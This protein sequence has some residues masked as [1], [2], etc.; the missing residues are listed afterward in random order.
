V[1]LQNLTD[2]EFNS[3]VRDSELPVIVDFWAAW[4]GPCKKISPLLEQLSVEWQGKAVVAKVNI[5]EA[6]TTALAEN[7]MSVPTIKVYKDGKEVAS[8]TGSLTKSIISSVIE[9]QF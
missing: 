7:I 3:V 4:C 6:G 1:S 9:K 2:E 8:L 5:D